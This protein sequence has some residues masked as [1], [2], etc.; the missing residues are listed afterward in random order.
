MTDRPLLHIPATCIGL[1]A[2]GVG[3]VVTLR[4]TGECGLVPRD[5]Q[6]RQENENRFRINGTYM[7]VIEDQ[8]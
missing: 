2:D 3:V 7:I 5:L 8:R 1:N 4:A 6:I